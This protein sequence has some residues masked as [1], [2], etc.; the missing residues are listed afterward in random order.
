MSPPI[1]DEANNQSFDHEAVILACAKGEIAALRQIYD[2]EAANLIGIATRI[3][4]RRD[5]AND[6][7]HDVFVQIWQR[8]VTF[9]P[10]RG[11]GR[12]W[13]ISIVRYRCFDVLR[14]TSRESALDPATLASIPDER[15]NAFSLLGSLQEAQALHRCLEQLDAPKRDVILLAYVD[16]LSQKQI[17]DQM[18]TPIGTVKT[19]VRRGLISLR[20][21]LS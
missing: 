10:A 8:A 13:I 5:L 18:K 17:A 21:C 19:W 9:D 4:R 7:I 14:Q 3:L 6:V 20:E 1:D 11:S 16:G 15:A 12:T 2:Y